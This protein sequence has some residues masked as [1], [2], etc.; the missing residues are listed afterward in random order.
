MSVLS[1]VRL[2]YVPHTLKYESQAVFK[3]VTLFYIHCGPHLDIS[4]YI[5][6]KHLGNEFLKNTITTQRST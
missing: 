1:K 4:R 6:E 2:I 5:K 3:T